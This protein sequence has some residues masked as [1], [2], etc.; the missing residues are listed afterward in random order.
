MSGFFGVYNR[1]GRPQDT[2]ILDR[3]AESIWHRGTDGINMWQDGVIAFGH[4]MLQTTPESLNEK[5]PYFDH[6]TDLVITS[7]ARIDNR[8]ELVYQLGL[9]DRFKTSIPDSQLILAAYNK[10]NE[11]CVDYL[12]GDFAFAI[13]DSKGQHLF[14]ARDIFGVKPFYYYLTKTTFIF[15]SE[16]KQVAEHPYVSLN[17]NDGI[18]AEYITDF[19]IRKDETHFTNIKK[20]PAAHRMIVTSKQ[21]NIDQYWRLSPQKRIWYKHDDEY[22][23][24]FTE[25]FGKAV[26]CRL[27]SPGKVGAYLS[28]GLDSSSIVGMAYTF[29]DLE[30]SKNIETFSLTFPGRDCDETNF[31][32][33]VINKWNLPHHEIRINEY[34]KVDWLRHI[35]QTLEVPDPPNQTMM[36]PLMEEVASNNIHIMLSGIGGDELFSGSP[37]GYL[38]QLCGGNIKEF[39][40]VY[41]YNTQSGSKKAFTKATANIL[42]PIIPKVIRKKLLSM[43]T[44]PKYPPWVSNRIVKHIEERINHDRKNNGS[45]YANL[46]DKSIFTRLMHPWVANVFEINDR[47]SSYYGVE[48]RYPFYD[49]RLVEFALAI[50]EYERI[51]QGITK[52]IVRNAGKYLLPESVI[53]RTDKAEFSSA[54][55][56]AIRSK[57][58]NGDIIF[59]E[60]S[61]KGFI[62]NEKKLY[63]YFSQFFDSNIN[64]KPIKYLWPLWFTY[65][66]NIY[67]SKIKNKLY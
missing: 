21:E 41:E 62:S 28:G 3:L 14:C 37:F 52:Y 56:E 33:S 9:I 57:E 54:F 45:E 26:Q 51:H 22:V 6:K 44:K 5:L 49:L 48:N 38:D 50:P 24:H 35:K 55:A 25:V 23:E 16:I 34:H 53:N 4:C 47:Y 1:D 17:L 20:L 60:I 2:N 11:N 59:Q 64:T 42:W 61:Q 66:I 40:Q 65:A 67:M 32:N 13:W 10:W 12:L 58:Q 29:D 63:E 31:I 46:A 15:G 19:Y 36:D 30:D 18:L 8:E 39:I 27:R 43:K 7:D